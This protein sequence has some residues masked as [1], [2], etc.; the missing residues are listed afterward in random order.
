MYSLLVLFLASSIFAGF[1]TWKVFG[2]DKEYG[3]LL[4]NTAT[5]EAQNTELAQ[6]LE[7]TE[8]EN[9]ELQ[10]KLE[11]KEDDLKEVERK[12][13]RIS[14]TV[15]V[16]EKLSKTDPE[17][18]QKYSKVFFLNEHYTPSRLALIDKIYLLN[19]ERPLE[20]HGDMWPF[21]KNLIEDAKENEVDLQIVSAYRSFGTQAALKSGYAVTYGAGTANQFSA[22]QGYSEHQLGTTVDF[23][24]ATLGTNFTN[25]ENSNGYTWLLDNAHKYGF[26]L[27]YPK[28][29]D[30]YQ[31]EPW[32]WR[33]V[34]RNLARHIYKNETSFYEMS[35]RDIDEYLAELFD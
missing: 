7:N 1:Q 11:Q 23:T 34:G 32:H 2:L 15:G 22:D 18:L 21:L 26:I 35:Q 29:N 30:Y 17:L 25:F 33:F 5:L 6:Q 16:L 9:K 13:S 28:G 19:Q 27:S 3:L 20:V 14:S 4:S 8:F 12:V 24:T 10:E 31:F